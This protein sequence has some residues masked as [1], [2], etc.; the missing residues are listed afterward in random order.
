MKVKDFTTKPVWQED[1]WLQK[2]AGETLGLEKEKEP[3][4]GGG[5]E[6][7]EGEGG[8]GDEKM[9]PAVKVYLILGTFLFRSI[10]SICVLFKTR[11]TFFTIET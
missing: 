3:G 5:T 9:T 2:H 6:G 4:E 7:G 1:S 10:S 8:E 11:R